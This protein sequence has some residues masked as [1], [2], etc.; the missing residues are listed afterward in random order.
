[1]DPEVLRLSRL[2]RLRAVGLLLLVVLAGMREV[3][4]ARPAQPAPA[5]DRFLEAANEEA[6]NKPKPKDCNPACKAPSVCA[7]GTCV[8][9]ASRP[10]HM[11]GE[12][13][14]A[15]MTWVLDSLR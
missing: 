13:S 1:M 12:H 10:A 6:K 11:P 7:D 2:W 5:A 15:Q 9:P 4:T 8:L 3:P 14:Q